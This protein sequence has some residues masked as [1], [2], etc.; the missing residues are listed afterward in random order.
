MM[1]GAWDFDFK[2]YVKKKIGFLSEWEPGVTGQLLVF[3]AS[4][5]ND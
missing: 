4:V 2:K 3:G 1:N 5:C